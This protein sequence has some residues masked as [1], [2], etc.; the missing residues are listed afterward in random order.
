MNRE[1]VT[2]EAI[3]AGAI[4]LIAQGLVVWKA[5]LTGEQIAWVNAI[6]NLAALAWTVLR[7][8]PQVTPLSDPRDQQGRPLTPEEAP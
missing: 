6:L 5:P 2:R 7:A 8:R 1:P 3:I 4:A